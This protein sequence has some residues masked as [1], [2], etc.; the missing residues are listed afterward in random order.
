MNL[1]LQ[2]RQCGRYGLVFAAN[3]VSLQSRK[4]SDSAFRLWIL[5]HTYAPKDPESYWTVSAERLAED[6]GFSRSTF[7][8]ALKSLKSSGLIEVDSSPARGDCNSYRLINA[9]GVKSV[10]DGSRRGVTCDTPPVS[11]V[12]T[13][14]GVIT[15]ET[16][17]NPLYSP[18]S[19]G[20][21]QDELTIYLGR[22]LT[23]LYK[24]LEGFSSW[25][26]CQFLMGDMSAYIKEE[27]FNF[28]TAF[29]KICEDTE[30][31]DPICVEIADQILSLAP[32]ENGR[33]RSAKLRRA[34]LTDCHEAI[35]QYGQKM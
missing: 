27:D 31:L 5:L 1:A 20:S 10:F 24:K 6:S 8:R 17:N 32:P 23:G 7:F 15:G 4:L 35:R 3:L 22:L 14:T 12:D 29:K 11:P 21:D 25:E 28:R 9:R 30:G 16:I 18:A 34:F 13:H 2:S 33:Q 19:G 26:Q